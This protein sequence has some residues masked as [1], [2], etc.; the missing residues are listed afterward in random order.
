MSNLSTAGGR[1]K[2]TLNKLQRLPLGLGKEGERQR[3][4]AE[5][6][7]KAAATESKCEKDKRKEEGG[8]DE[9]VYPVLSQVFLMLCLL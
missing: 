9:C 5:T 1:K 4:T 2:K 6:Q 8:P 7:M 3:E